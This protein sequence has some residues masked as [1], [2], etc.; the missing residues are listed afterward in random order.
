MP[1]FQNGWIPFSSGDRGT[2]GIPFTTSCLNIIHF[3]PANCFGGP[4]DRA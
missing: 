4:P 2:P 1:E 3:G